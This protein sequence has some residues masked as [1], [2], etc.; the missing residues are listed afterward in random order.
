MLDQLV[1][2]WTSKV[3]RAMACAA[4][5]V[6]ERSNRHRRQSC[7]GRARPRPPVERRE[8]RAHPARLSDEEKQ[9]IIAA[10]C[11]E[12]FCDL[13]PA[14]VYMTLL[15]EGTYLCSERQMYRVLSER[16]LV[17]ERRRGHVHNRYTT[18]RLVATKP[19]QV[20]TWDITA[21]R[22]PTKGEVCLSLPRRSCR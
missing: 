21:L 13:A 6:N 20:W 16:G 12:R 4:F 7:D 1:E 3:G 15:D 17:R 19:N 11:E 9:Q 14:Q 8:R 18:P 10:L 5:G 22:G 2:R